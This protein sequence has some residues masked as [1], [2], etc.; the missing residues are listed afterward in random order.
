MTS[1]SQQWIEQAQYDLE[2]AK[3]MQASG[4]YLYVLFCCQQ[5]VEKS[6][7]A[8]IVERTGQFPPRIHNLPRLAEA[9]KLELDES[10]MDFLAE[11]STYYVQTRYPE[12]I[13]S[14]TD[15]LTR[16]KTEQTLRMSEKMVTWLLSM[17]K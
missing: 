2:T 17:R 16:E 11:L 6:L 14:L 10:R 5:A 15:S 3:A 7:K 9:G 12:E 4:R 13:R 1:A 8:L